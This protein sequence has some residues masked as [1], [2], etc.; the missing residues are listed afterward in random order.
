MKRL[1]LTIFLLT[2]ICILSSC[3][4]EHSYSEWSVKTEAT[5]SSDGE[6]IRVCEC[7]ETQT[8]AIE[9][10]AHQIITVSPIPPTCATAG[11]TAGSCCSVCGI[12][13][14]EPQLIQPTHNYVPSVISQPTCTA[15]GVTKYTCS[16]CEAS[17]T[18]ES[19]PLGHNLKNETCTTAKTCTVCESTFGLPL[20][21][22]VNLGICER[23]EQ[24]VQ[25]K[26]SLPSVPLSVSVAI[27]GYK[28]EMSITELSYAFTGNNIVITYSG[29]KT[30][31]EGELTDGR[32]FCGFS[33]R[34]YD[35]EGNL[36]ASGSASVFDLY[37]G[38]SFTDEQFFIL[39]L[40]DISDFYTLVIEDYIP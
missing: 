24:F 17:Y 21:H 9:K 22:T 39:S 14:T 40:S 36:A 26:I 1:C 10:K 27:D 11:Y 28:T 2:I 4:H 8:Q 12:F 38:E 37:I 5:C 3:G 13:T 6:K 15:K 33:Y 32:Y 31:D 23:C 30:K 16:A 25:P 7:G 35:A 18:E 34:L 29:I 20:G 19:E